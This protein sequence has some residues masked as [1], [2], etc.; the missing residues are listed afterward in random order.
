LKDVRLRFI[1][2]YAKFADAEMDFQPVQ[3]I[4]A[5]DSFDGS[6]RTRTFSSKMNDD[7]SHDPF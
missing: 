5:N 4:P 3:N 7:E 1:S 2:K 6:V